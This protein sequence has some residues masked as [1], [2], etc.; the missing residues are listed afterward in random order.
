MTKEEKFVVV[1]LIRW[2]RRQN[3]KWRLRRPKYGTAATGW[4]IEARRKNQDL[5]IEAKYIDG[6]F[7]ASFS[8]LV[9]APLAN[10]PQRFMKRKYRSWSYS[11]CWAIGASYAQRNI[12][13]LLLDYFARNQ[14]FWGHYQQDLRAKYI[15]FV[16][17]GKVAKISFA[18]VIEATQRY[19]TQ[20]SKKKRNER[21]VVANKLLGRLLKFD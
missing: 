2:F 20:A 11:I 4:D 1:P 10:R 14:R 6:S 16:R 13:Q 5:L 17:D 19:K 9:T 7:L 8:G 12:Y 15:F 3:A 21:R 18:K